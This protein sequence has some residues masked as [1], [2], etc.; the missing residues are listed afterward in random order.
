MNCSRICGAAL[1]S[2]LFAC[3]GTNDERSRSPADTPS[4][5]AGF[6]GAFGDSAKRDTTRPKP[7]RVDTPATGGH[8][9]DI[10]AASTT[11]TA[12][13]APR[14]AGTTDTASA[15]SGSPGGGGQAGTLDT[16]AA[17]TPGRVGPRVLRPVAGTYD[18][19]PAP[20]APPAS[21]QRTKR[22]VSRRAAGVRP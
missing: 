12:T 3:G 11:D 7:P 6:T 18:T 22:G 14:G 10:P 17:I 5:D 21:L 16:A 13:V 1:V 15:G 9:A 2:T 4:P 8:R 20:L 19:A